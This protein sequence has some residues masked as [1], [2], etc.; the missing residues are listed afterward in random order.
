MSTA[1]EIGT[2]L[3][4][5]ARLEK[6]PI[7][8][9]V[10]NVIPDGCVPLSEIDRC[11]AKVMFLLASNSE[12][13]PVYLSADQADKACGG[14]MQWSGFCEANP[15]IPYFVSTGHKDFRNG[16]A[17]YLRATP[18]IAEESANQAGAFTPPGDYIIFC[19][20]DKI[21]GLTLENATMLAITC[22]G[23]AENIRNM[24]AL[25]H[26]RGTNIFQNVIM[27]TGPAC[28]TLM[29]YP[30]GLAENA[31][32]TC[33]FIGPADPTGNIWFPPD[34]MALGIPITLAQLMAD[35]VE[36][37]FLSKRPQV[38]FPENR[39][40]LKYR[41]KVSEAATM[42]GAEESNAENGDRQ[43]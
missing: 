20:A 22:F 32:K 10:S 36:A 25:V 12:M 18:E 40:E 3:K 15:M 9:M 27:A 28:S 16:M 19:A 33:A 23:M 5:A 39:I 7:Y 37:S 34:Y 30:A 29:G 13:P 1:L 24:A 21:R 8:I 17:E 4:E 6:Q 2:L 43:E 26:F 42:P 11:I 31:P 35:D 38:A 41:P 14:G